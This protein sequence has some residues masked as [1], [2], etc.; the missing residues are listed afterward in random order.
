[1]KVVISKFAQLLPFSCPSVQLFDLLRLFLSLLCTQ[2]Q[3]AGSPEMPLMLQVTP[4]LLV[5]FCCSTLAV[6]GCPDSI[7]E[8]RRTYLYMYLQF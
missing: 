2:R 6:S 5:S 4:L 7:N 8:V 1:M 3:T